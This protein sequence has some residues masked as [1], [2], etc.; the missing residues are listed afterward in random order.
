MKILQVTNFFKPSWESG[1][2][3][4]VAYELSKK[5][6]ERGHEVTVYTTDGFKSRLNVE[7]NKP[8]DVDGIKTYYFRNLSSYLARKMVLPIPYYLP[9]VVRKEIM[10]FD[11]IHIHE[12]R[13]VLAIVIHH[14]AKKY[15]IPYVLQPRGSVPTISKS[16][17]KKLFDILFGQAIIGD[18]NKI[19]AS[20]KIESEQYRDVF[21]KLNNEKIVH[22]P[23]GIDLETYQNLPQK[24]EFKKKHSIKIDE[25]IILFLSRI[26]ERKGADMLIE[27]FSKL[28]SKFDRVKL[29]IAGPDEGYL[30][31]LKLIVSKLDIEREVIF[32]G[33]LYEKD[34]LEAYV[35]ADVF[36]LPSKSKEESFGN[37][38][39]E[40][41]A[42]GT[43][44]IITN[45]C[46]VSEWISD[47][48]GYVVNYDKDQLRD[49]IFKVLSDGELRR[50]FGERGKKLVM[51]EFDW[52][53]IVRKLEGV[54][55]NCFRG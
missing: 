47:D 14:Y 6:V 52:D 7:K 28:K 26:H 1:G 9:M 11:V 30:D 27:V 13:T 19:I 43:P 16:K 33:P 40:A 4:R 46:G 45:N 44:V 37:V 10:D 29:V 22:M 15:G 34:K 21:P 35:D 8:V 49:A 55:E 5:L 2:P 23:N 48:V 31:T 18:A 20:S 42:C 39:L 24:G 12:Y 36:V 3:A 17:Q 41:L 53:G 25:K 32:P 51:E 50:R 54:Y 38:V